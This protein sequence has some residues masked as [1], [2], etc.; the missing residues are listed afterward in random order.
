MATIEAYNRNLNFQVELAKQNSYTQ[1]ALIAQFVWTLYGGKPLP[2][3]EDCF[4][5]S[6]A[7]EQKL[8][9][10]KVHIYE[11]QWKAFAIEHNRRR[12]KNNGG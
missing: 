7:Y 1:A 11:Q 9:E 4:S 3:Y 5:V 8:R 2:N 12:N 6:G 10:E